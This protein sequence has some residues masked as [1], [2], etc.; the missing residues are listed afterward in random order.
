MSRFAA[1]VL[2]ALAGLAVQA[3][4]L[5][6]PKPWITGWDKPVDP[7]GDCRFDRKGERLTI[8]VPAGRE[9]VLAVG[10]GRDG[11]TAPRLL[12]DIE[13][14]FAAE[15][16]V[17]GNFD[18]YDDGGRWAGILLLAGESGAKLSLGPTGQT[19]S[20]TSSSTAATAPRTV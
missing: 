17:G 19:G 12:R 15:V 1:A 5:P 7:N 11:L 20:L 10:L 4:P 16:Q 3:T 13:V 9:R 8:T 6:P 2:C 18:E 14:D